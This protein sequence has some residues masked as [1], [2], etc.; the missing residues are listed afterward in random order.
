MA[1]DPLSLLMLVPGVLQQI[2]GSSGNQQTTQ[3]TKSDPTR[4]ESPNVGFMDNAIANLL[5]QNA[6]ATSNWGRPAGMPGINTSLL[7]NTAGLIGKEG[8]NTIDLYNKKG[9]QTP[10]QKLKAKT[11]CYNNCVKMGGGITKIMD[12]TKKCTESLG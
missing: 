5:L 1:F 8:E 10:A 6:N 3:T 7:M 11:D 4:Y 12:C 9:L 2:F